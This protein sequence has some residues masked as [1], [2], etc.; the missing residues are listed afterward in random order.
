MAD[1]SGKSVLM[2][3]AHQGFRD[4]E[5]EQP[6]HMLEAAGARVTV[7]SSS[8]APAQ[9][10]L[11]ATARPDILV[12]T[13]DPTAFDAVIFVGGSGASEYWDNASAHVLARDAYQAG[14]VVAAICIAPVTLAR[15]KLLRGKRAT[16]FHSVRDH[17]EA[18]GAHVTDARVERDG[19]LITA[20]GPEAAA[21]FGE[22][23][24]A[25][26]TQG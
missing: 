21:H 15:T 22:A 14:K 17:L 20:S 2:V 19:T 3:I 7:A 23:L 8:L 5:Y 25:A 16:A 13:A 11:G 6:R 26:L 1:L 4:E 9:G 18:E 12:G 24:V 10:M